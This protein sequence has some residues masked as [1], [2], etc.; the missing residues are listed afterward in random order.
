[1]LPHRFPNRCKWNFLPVNHY[2]RLLA[3]LLLFAS[4]K[5]PL[6][7]GRLGS[8][9]PQKETTKAGRNVFLTGL[10]SQ[11]TS[12]SKPRS[13]WRTGCYHVQHCSRPSFQCELEYYIPP[14]VQLMTKH[15]PRDWEP[16]GCIC[17]LAVCSW[18]TH[19]LSV[20]LYFFICAMGIAMLARWSTEQGANKRKRYK[21]RDFA[22]CQGSFS[23]TVSFRSVGPRA[24][25]W[26]WT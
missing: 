17:F 25:H 19:L 23:C 21:R 9:L 6:S 1:M 20:S 24:K 14:N 8:E 10:N 5:S 3:P 11:K 4:R 15:K 2:I 13:C 18:A 16:E 7:T 22:D 12:A 26:G